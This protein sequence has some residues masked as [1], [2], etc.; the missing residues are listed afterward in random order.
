VNDR[1]SLWVERERIADAEHGPFSSMRWKAQAARGRPPAQEPEPEP[2]QPPR[3]RRGWILPA[4]ALFAAIGA[5]AVATVAL[6]DDGGSSTEDALAPALVSGGKAA[7]TSL[8]GKVYASAGPGVVSVQVGNGSGTGFVVATDGTIVTNNHVVGDAA[9]AEVRFNDTGRLLQAQV[10]GSDPSSDLAVLKVDPSQAGDLRPLVLADSDDVAIGDAVVAIG[11]PFNLDRTVT[12]GIISGVGRSIQAPNGFQIDKVLQTDAAINPGNSGG[13]L[14]DARGR[15]IGVNSQI[16]TS[17]GGSQGIGFAIP[18]NTVRDIL[19]QLR[20]GQ[21]VERPYIGIQMAPAANGV[22]VA[23]ITA[24]GPAVG[25]GLKAGDVITS[26]D[27]KQVAE[28]DDVPSAIS[29]KKPGDEVT[30]QVMRGGKQETVT[31]TLGIRPKTP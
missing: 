1:H 20:R 13:P 7:P 3:K 16:A 15:V 2:A 6:L 10:L 14:L 23:E 30:I 17:S 26:V 19:P 28:P 22:K 5:L 25:S 27:G 24:G 9:T 8:V 4:L 12:S 31:V 18:A 29:A 21:T 11:H